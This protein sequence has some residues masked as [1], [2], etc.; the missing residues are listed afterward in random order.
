VKSYSKFSLN[1][2]NSLILYSDFYCCNFLSEL[3]YADFIGKKVFLYGE[4]N[5]GKTELTSRFLTYIQ[6]T[7]DVQ[8]IFVFDMGPERFKVKNT[9]IGGKL[10]DYNMEFKHNPKIHT[11]SYSV[12]PP[13]SVSKTQQEVYQNCLKN[14]RQ[15][16]A[17]LAKIIKKILLS[18]ERI[19]LII[20]DFSIFLHLGS[21]IPFLKMLKTPHTVF[22]NAY[23]GQKLTQDYNSNISWRERII[24]KNLSQHF[25]YPIL[26]IQ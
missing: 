18:K 26:L 5:T 1:R 13:R 14:Y 17:D 16:Y 21:P 11:Y 22:V 15:I 24:V 3:S 10:S 6:H 19:A 23:F 20:N 12:I 9:F 25:D 8:S 2:K 7:A 4:S